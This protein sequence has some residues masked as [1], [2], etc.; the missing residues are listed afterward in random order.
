MGIAALP[1]SEATAIF[2]ISPMVITLFSIV[3]LGER[4]GVW[5]WFAVVAG[6]VGAIIM[7]RPGTASFQL[8]GLFPMAAAV[9]YAALHI[10]TRK[11]GAT[12]KASAMAFYIQL[13]FVIVSATIG[14]SFGDGRYAGTGDPSVDFLLREW[15]WPQTSDLWIMIGI[16]VASAVGGYTISQAYRL[17]EAA[18]IAPFEYISLVLAIIWGVTLFDEIPDGIAWLGIGLIF[19]SGLLVFWREAVLK[20]RI[21]AARPTPLKR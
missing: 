21:A 15:V 2:F 6:L 3:F 4:V 13:T 5:R 16:G 9:C 17:G 10:F 14:L 20:K 7:L 11:L 19:A 12:D 18:T 1:L 8:A